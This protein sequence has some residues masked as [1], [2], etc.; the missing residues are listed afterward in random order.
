VLVE[1]Q[2]SLFPG[3]LPHRSSNLG[4]G[5]FCVRLS[6]EKEYAEA[7]AILEKAIDSYPRAGAGSR[8]EGPRRD[9]RARIHRLG[10][11]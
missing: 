7:A 8:R 11:Q 2:G 9:D 5:P 1:E 3:I 4:P 6:I 10:A